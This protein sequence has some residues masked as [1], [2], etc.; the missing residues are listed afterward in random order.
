MT[1]L[2]KATKLLQR[3]G[4]SCVLMSENRVLTSRD[5]GIAPIL[6]RIEEGESLQGMVCADKIIGKAAAMLLITAGV[7]AAYGEVMSSNAKALMEAQGIKVSY[8]EL[9]ERIINRAGDGP[10]PME[11]AI[12]AVTDPKEAPKVLRQALNEIKKANGNK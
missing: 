5:R 2:S 11:C 7:V 8:G 10:C 12:A 3:E 1:K 6:Q 9:T 4:Y